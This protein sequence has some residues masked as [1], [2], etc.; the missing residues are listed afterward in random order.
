MFLGCV[1]GFTVE[2]IVILVAFGS[3]IAVAVERAIRKGLGK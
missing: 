3:G 1:C 2:A